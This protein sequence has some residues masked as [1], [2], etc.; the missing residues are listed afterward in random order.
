[1][2]EVPEPLRE[3]IRVSIE[4]KLARNAGPVAL[5]ATEAM[6]KTIKEDA[7]PGQYPQRFV[8]EFVAFTQEL[9][10]YFNCAGALDRLYAMEA[11]DD[12]QKL[13]VDEL[14]DAMSQLS[15][16]AS[17]TTTGGAVSPRRRARRF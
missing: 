15:R 12:D 16:S 13:M 4:D 3:E 2:P 17:A 14:R 5:F 9:K 8:D 6:L 7:Y 1:M 10:R 11:L